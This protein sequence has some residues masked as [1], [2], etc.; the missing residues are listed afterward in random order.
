MSCV[1]FCRAAQ[2]WREGSCLGLVREE[3]GGR[4]AH[5]KPSSDSHRSGDAA[6]TLFF[7]FLLCET[8]TTTHHASRGAVREG[9]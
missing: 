1:P 8:E 9:K 4:G 3:G 5:S 2:S 7:S 6:H